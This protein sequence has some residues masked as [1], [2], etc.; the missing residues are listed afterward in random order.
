M[1]KLLDSVSGFV[2]SK[3]RNPFIN[4]FIIAWI[5][6]NWKPVTFFIFSNLSAGKK[7]WIISEHYSDIWHVLIYPAAWTIFILIAVPAILSGVG[8]ISKF[9][10]K[11]NLENDGFIARAKNKVEDDVLAARNVGDVNK[12]I[13]ELKEKNSITEANLSAERTNNLELTRKHSDEFYKLKDKYEL[14]INQLKANIETIEID[15]SIELSKAKEDWITQRQQIIDDCE[16]QKSTLKDEIE[17]LRKEKDIFEKEAVHNGTE[18]EKCR[19]G[20]L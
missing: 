2:D 6:Y 8:F 12:Y 9:I 10:K 18:L 16:C 11:F 13:E 4:T 19:Q 5:A 20:K 7:I 1:E 3:L 14:E 17:K 15:S